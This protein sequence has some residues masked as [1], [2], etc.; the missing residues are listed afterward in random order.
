MI[1]IGFQI[2]L[3]NG[4][5]KFVLLCQI[6]FAGG[7]EPSYGCQSFAQER[8]FSSTKDDWESC[9]DKVVE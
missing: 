3:N 4:V 5:R 1:E 6:F 7:Q 8:R 2:S 9:F